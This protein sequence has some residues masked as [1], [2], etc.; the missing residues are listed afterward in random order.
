MFFIGQNTDYAISLE[1]SHKLKEI[2][3]IHAEAYEA[4]ELKHG[5]L[6]LVTD[7][8]PV[9]FISSVDHIHD[10]MASNIKEVRNFG[11]K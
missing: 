11:K 9:I 5:A 7:E 6:A 4:G 3:Y 10:K 2:F 8:M 1:G